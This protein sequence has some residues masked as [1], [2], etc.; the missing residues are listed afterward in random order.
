MQLSIR[1]KTSLG[2]L[3]IYH[4]YFLQ[5]DFHDAT[6][7]KQGRL[8]RLWG[9][10]ICICWCN[11]NSTVRVFD[12]REP[13]LCEADAGFVRAPVICHGN[14]RVFAAR[15]GYQPDPQD[16]FAGAVLIPVENGHEAVVLH[17]AN[18]RASVRWPGQKRLSDL[19]GDGV[20]SVAAA[21]WE[22]V[23]D[24]D[25]DVQFCEPE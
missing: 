25:L 6:S 9:L 2:A 23:G 14:S 4:I 18:A 11:F 12:R 22:A 15:T 24:G 17:H 13:R 8:W 20:R 7:L 5:P 19:F 21:G 10:S 16:G 1:N 3:I